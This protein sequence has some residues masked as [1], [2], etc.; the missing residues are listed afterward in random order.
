MSPRGHTWAPAALVALL[1][2]LSVTAAAQAEVP[3][4]AKTPPSQDSRRK[5][6]LGVRAITSPSGNGGLG[7]GLDGTYY[8]QPQLGVG[9]EVLG[10]A[11]GLG[12]EY[13]RRCTY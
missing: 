13:A 8:V 1:F 11:M 3:T 12:D 5:V 6:A 10:L 4:E 7:L 2:S 9:A